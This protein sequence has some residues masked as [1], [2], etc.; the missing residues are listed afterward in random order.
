MSY[1]SEDRIFQPKIK[2]TPPLW[3]FKFQGPISRS[4]GI[5][6][7]REWYR[8]TQLVETNQMVYVSTRFGAGPRLNYIHEINLSNII[9]GLD[10]AN[11]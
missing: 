11:Y 7:P 9:I 8:S 10:T 4:T 3:F 1:H 6:A 5:S 2:L